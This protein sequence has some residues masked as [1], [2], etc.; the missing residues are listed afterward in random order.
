MITLHFTAVPRESEGVLATITPSPAPDGLF[1]AM[2]QSVFETDEGAQC[3]RKGDT[4]E[5]SSPSRTF[6]EIQ[7][8]VM[9]LGS[10]EFNIRE[11]FLVK[12]AHFEPNRI[13]V[14]MDV[15]MDVD[16]FAEHVRDK[17]IL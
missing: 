15:N 12:K 16:K 13:E 2:R 9:L 8:F 10:G 6:E 11:G 14:V 1:L 5:I 4:L 17:P 7:E 3:D